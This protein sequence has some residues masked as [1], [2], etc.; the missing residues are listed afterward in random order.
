MLAWSSV[1]F[2]LSEVYR[3]VTGALFG[4]QPPR[5]VGPTLKA[6]QAQ[7]GLGWPAGYAVGRTLMQQEIAARGVLVQREDSLDYDPQRAE[8]TYWM[9][10]RLRSDGTAADWLGGL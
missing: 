5:D 6:E 3:P 8:F 7:P 4:M 9:T 1:G 10:T 2:N